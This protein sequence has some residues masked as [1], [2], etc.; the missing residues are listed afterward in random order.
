MSVCWMGTRGERGRPKANGAFGFWR[1]LSRYSHYNK[2]IG[3]SKPNLCGHANHGV[4]HQ[5]LQN[6]LGVA[7]VHADAMVML[8]GSH[9]VDDLMIKLWKR[10]YV[11]DDE[12][13]SIVQQTQR[14]TRVALISGGKSSNLLMTKIVGKTVKKTLGKGISD[15]PPWYCVYCSQNLQLVSLMAMDQFIR[16]SLRRSSRR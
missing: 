11:L 16:L 13:D 2:G 10:G 12:S 7:D 8:N 9:T 5:L 3:R 1:A 6:H 14:G 15:D 4:H